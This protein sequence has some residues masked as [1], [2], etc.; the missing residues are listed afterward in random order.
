MTKTVEIPDEFRERT[1]VGG[2]SPDRPMITVTGN[3]IFILIVAFEA[4]GEPEAVR[5]FIDGNRVAIVPADPGR[6]NAYSVH[7]TDARSEF[8][9]AWLK[10]ELERDTQ[11]EGQFPLERDGDLWVVD[12][13]PEGDDPAQGEPIADGGQAQP[14]FGDRVTFIDSKGNEYYGIVLE[15][16]LG[17]EYIAVAVV[18]ADPRKEY[19]GTRWKVETSVYP[20]PDIDPEY[21][22]TA[23]TFKLG[24]DA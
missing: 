19:I 14:E 3:R 18:Q 23:H 24:W 8:S 15:P 13:A 16:L 9:G 2:Y 11:P 6:A 7:G 12:F 1:P 21:T 17:D 10:D 20:H 5:C 4:M 22:A